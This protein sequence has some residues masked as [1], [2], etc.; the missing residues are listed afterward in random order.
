MPD[1]DTPELII[2]EDILLANIRGMADF[3][4]KNGVKLRPHFKTHKI[5]EIAR[6]Q[7]AHGAVGITV[8]KLGEA[9]VALAAGIADIFVACPIIGGAKL[10][11]LLALAARARVITAV[12][13]PEA[14]DQLNA[15]ALQNNRVMEI[16]LEVDTGLRRCGLP[17]GPELIALARHVAALP[18]LRLLG[19][20]THAGHVYGV[21]D[22]AKVADIGA[23][24]GAVMAAL[25]DDLRRAGIPIAEV[26]VGSTPT[27]PHSG[28]VPG[29]TEIRPGNYVF[30]DAIQIGL[31]VA[32]P[33]DCALRVLAAVVSAPAPRRRI[34]DAGSK[35]LALDKGAHGAAVVTGFGAILGHPGWELTRLSEEMGILEAAGDSPG[36]AIGDIIEI[37]PNHA[38]T[39]INLASQ[40]NVRRGG[41]TVAAWPVAARGRVR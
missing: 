20:M 41:E 1:I 39:A 2:D 17:P 18:G 13:S 5:P 30:N 25:A 12:D 32:A 24:E 21:A 9:E 26:S 27:V 22:P 23:A 10:R 38:C 35:V 28:R 40:V 34:I 6:L 29:V 14:A 4:K 8:A 11:R 15:A 19:L 33:G 31:G 36:P 3:A 16:Y 7:L 37:I